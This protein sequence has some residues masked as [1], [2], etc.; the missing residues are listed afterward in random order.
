MRGDVSKV[1]C[2]E[3][4]SKS[5]REF[6]VRL[7][8][9]RQ[10]NIQ[11]RP[12]GPYY[13]IVIQGCRGAGGNIGRSSSKKGGHG[14]QYA[15]V[16]VHTAFGQAGAKAPPA[17]VFKACMRSSAARCNE[18]P[19]NDNVNAIAMTV[20]IRR[21]GAW[22]NEVTG[23]VGNVPEGAEPPKL[24]TDGKAKVKADE[25]EDEELPKGKKGKGKGKKGR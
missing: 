13:K 7:D 9:E 23:E 14:T 2:F 10:V 1:N 4:N 16:L 15:T 25:D 20:V 17:E 6:K 8:C 5:Y 22:I 3:Y 18:N 11:D 12:D 21:D 19:D 24:K